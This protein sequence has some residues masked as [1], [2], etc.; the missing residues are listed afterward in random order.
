MKNTKVIFLILIT[1]LLCGFSD[2]K[3]SYA[4]LPVESKHIYDICYSTNG[5]VLVVAD[6]TNIKWFSTDNYDLLSVYSGVHKRQI[7]TIDISADSTLLASGGKDSTIVIWDVMGGK[8]KDIL[9][10]HSGIV[11]TLQFTSD[12]KYLVSGGTDDKIIVYDI[13]NRK[14][15]GIFKD[16]EDDIT[17]LV[18]SPD[19]KILYAASAAGNINVYDLVNNTLLRILPKINNWVRDISLSSDGETLI[20]GGDDSKLRMW[21]VK[22]LS[23]I[24]LSN[25]YFYWNYKWILSVKFMDY[26]SAYAIGGLS[27]TLRICTKFGDYIAR[28]GVPIEDIEFYPNKSGII[29]IAVAT[30]GKGV[31]LIDGKNLR[32]VNRRPNVHQ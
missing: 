29:R 7:L 18:V 2:T 1:E 31:L 9:N 23:D 10:V 3:S 16:F 14:I 5:G 6:N 19:N 28:L 13:E 11:T 8:V 17:S 27:G 30:W 15:K 32:G 21:S 26:S 20:S 25:T 22:N 12:N 24:H 4:E